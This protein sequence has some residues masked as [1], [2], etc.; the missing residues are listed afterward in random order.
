MY[1]HHFGF[2]L[3][4]GVFFE[5]VYILYMILHI[6]SY[7][8]WHFFQSLQISQLKLKYSTAILITLQYIRMWKLKHSK[9]NERTNINFQCFITFCQNSVALNCFYN[10][11]Q[12]H[13]YVLIFVTHISL[14]QLC[15][16][17]TFFH[18][19]KQELSLKNTDDL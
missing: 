3:I 2:Y 13:I 10:Q 16:F 18:V 9:E 19:F 5:S 12:Y 8:I 1:I 6:G 14:N 15:I 11:L 17:W 4:C 7:L